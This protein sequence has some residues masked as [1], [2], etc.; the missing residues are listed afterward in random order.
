MPQNPNC[1]NSKAPEKA[2]CFSHTALIQI[3][4]FADLWIIPGVGRFQVATLGV[5]Q[6]RSP[7]KLTFRSECLESYLD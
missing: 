5:L 4:S 6:E 3:N 7:L 1:S 2:F